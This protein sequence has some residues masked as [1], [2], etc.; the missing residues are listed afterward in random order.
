MREIK[1]CWEEM[2]FEEYKRAISSV[3]DL[4]TATDQKINYEL[5]LRER[6]RY[7]L[8]FV[9]GVW[10]RYSIAAE[11]GSDT[12]VIEYPEECPWSHNGLITELQKFSFIVS[13]EKRDSN[14]DWPGLLFRVTTKP[15]GTQH[16][17]CDTYHPDQGIALETYPVRSNPL[18]QSNPPSNYSTSL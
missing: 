15:S 7:L 9:H 6:Y 8:K 14:D 11:R 18:C 16:S 13:W 5:T 12:F 17:S 3:S 1:Y 10:K 4:I 2:N